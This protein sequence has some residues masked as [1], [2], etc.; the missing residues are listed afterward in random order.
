MAVSYTHLYS[1]VAGKYIEE[2][3]I[4]AIAITNKNPLVTS[5][6]PFYFRVCFIDSYQGV[7][8]AKYAVSSLGASS[9]AVDVYKRQARCLRSFSVR[10]SRRHS[11]WR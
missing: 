11:R 7:A 10:C 3:E 1:L 6:N 2:A 4:P 9:A 5:N 8:L